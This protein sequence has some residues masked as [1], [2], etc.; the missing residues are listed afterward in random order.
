MKSDL[1]ET[2]YPLIM[3]NQYYLSVETPGHL[4]LPWKKATS[5]WEKSFFGGEHQGPNLVPFL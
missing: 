2:E 1:E 5:I 4:F 3:C